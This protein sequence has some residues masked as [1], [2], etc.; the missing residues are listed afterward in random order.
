MS[1]SSCKGTHYSHLQSCSLPILTYICEGEN[2]EEDHVRFTPKRSLRTMRFQTV[3][4]M[5]QPQSC[6]H[7]PSY[8]CCLGGKYY[9]V[10]M[11]Y[12]ET[13]RLKQLDTGS[14]SR[15][16]RPMN[17]FCCGYSGPVFCD[18]TYKLSESW[19]P[20]SIYCCISMPDT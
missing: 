15:T 1:V 19:E 7:I 5:I 13:Q 16:Y 10:K 20:I 8:L 18:Q 12:C 3:V 4:D 17:K 11:G 2:A 14:S 9:V 6:L